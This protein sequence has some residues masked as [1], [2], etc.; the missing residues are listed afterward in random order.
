MVSC[1]WNMKVTVLN[2]KMLKE[3]RI[4]HDHCLNGADIAITYNAN[5][6]FNAVGK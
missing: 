5:N 6:H 2:M 1:M 4:W 3:Y